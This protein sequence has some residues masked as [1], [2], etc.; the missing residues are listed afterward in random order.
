[1]YAHAYRRTGSYVPDI[2]FTVKTYVKLFFA[3]ERKNKV[4]R[5]FSTDFFLHELYA[6]DSAE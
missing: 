3:T 5:N 2:N 6:H 1:M 4:L